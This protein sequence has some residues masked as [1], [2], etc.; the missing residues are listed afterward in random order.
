MHIF[1]AYFIFTVLFFKIKY[2]RTGHGF[3]SSRSLKSSN[4]NFGFLEKH[5]NSIVA[6]KKNKT[7]EF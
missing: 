5:T 4:T 1:I 3:N 7:L 6:G 2:N